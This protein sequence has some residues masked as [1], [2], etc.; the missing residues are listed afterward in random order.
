MI[1]VSNINNKGSIEVICGSMFS[2]KT[3]ELIRRLKLCI[4]AKQKV[5]IFNSYLDTRYAKEHIVSHDKSM[6]KATGVK[7]ASEI[8]KKVQ[9]DTHVVGIDEA[10]FFDDDIIDVANRLADDGKRVIIAGLDM[11]WRGKP[12][13]NM[14]KLMAISEYVTKNLAICMVCGNP[15][16]YTQKLV[17]GKDRIVVG[18][19]DKYEARCRRC[20]NPEL[21][22]ASEKS[23]K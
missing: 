15:A 19:S 7:K 21:S 18:A 9:D 23:K 11:D 2:G 12:F 22:V 3:Q 16:H 8:L 4:I 20:F 14:A 6:L 5:Q 17:E 1:N 13:I 10:H